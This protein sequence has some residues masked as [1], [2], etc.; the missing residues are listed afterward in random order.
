MILK[1]SG[2]DAEAGT[3]QANAVEVGLF[4]GALLGPLT[5]LVALVEQLD[6]LELLIG[7]GQQA[8]GVLKLDAQLVG[9]ARQVFAALDRG[10]GIGRIGEM[11]GIVD[12]GTL[13]LGQ[14]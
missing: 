12:P 11:R 1:A 6:L 13:L 7:F 14:D 10:L 4:A 9:R 3:R 5:G 2:D 8:L